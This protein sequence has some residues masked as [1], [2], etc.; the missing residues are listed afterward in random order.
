MRYLHEL[1]FEHNGEALQ[2]SL[3]VQIVFNSSEKLVTELSNLPQKNI[4]I[5]DN[6]SILIFIKVLK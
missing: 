5:G 2:P 1:N 4:T 3:H 6:E